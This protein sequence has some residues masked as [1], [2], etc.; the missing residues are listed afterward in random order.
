MFQSHGSPCSQVGSYLEAISAFATCA[1]AA[2]EAPG[3]CHGSLKSASNLANHDV[4]TTKVCTVWS[5]KIRSHTDEHN[6]DVGL[7]G[8]C[9]ALLACKWRKFGS[10]LAN[11]PHT[12]PSVQND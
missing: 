10:C 2:Q 4:C 9:C 11:L 12:K 6:D 1:D 5:R 7:F 8:C 3:Y